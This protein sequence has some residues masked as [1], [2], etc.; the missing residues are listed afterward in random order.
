MIK[1]G[2]VVKPLTE[3]EKALVRERIFVEASTILAKQQLAHLPYVDGE[4]IKEGMKRLKEM[5][6]LYL[7]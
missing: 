3:K 1:D 6:D 7:D 5:L 4:K 2:K